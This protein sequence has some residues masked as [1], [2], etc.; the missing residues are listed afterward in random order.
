MDRIIDIHS[1]ILPGID[2]GS[3]NLE[4]SINI[5]HYLEKVGITDI[6]C[7][8]H[9][10]KNTK[11]NYNE[12]V[13][14]QLL[15]TLKQNVTNPNTKLYLGNEVYATEDMVDLL[16]KKEISTI[17]N[18]RYLLIE[19][20]LSGYLNNLQNILCELIGGG[21][22][23]VIAHPERYLFLQKNKKEIKRLLEFDCLLQCNVES[24]TN[25]YGKKAK[26]LMNYLLKNNLVQAVATDTH[27]TG[28]EKQLRKAYKKL[29]HLVGNQE[30]QKLVYE[31]PLK[32]LENQEVK[33]NLEY[34][35]KL[36]K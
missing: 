1:H 24:L 30:Y 5:I 4:E 32:I 36:E 21:I 7:T 6:I 19:L 35:M 3:K 33:G 12:M 27:Y 26:K 28:N 11:Y 22:T 18:S 13:R 31:N 29:K 34:L 23:P 10:V 17:N 20:P 9:Y 16:E 8:S 2:D 15:E 14:K 25:K